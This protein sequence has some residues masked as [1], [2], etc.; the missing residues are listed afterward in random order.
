M[1]K[2]A[3]KPSAALR[4]VDMFT[5][6]TAVDAVQAVEEDA[7][8][9]LKVSETIETSAE[10][11]RANAMFTAEHLSKHWN[12]SKPETA[13]FRLTEK[14]GNLFL[15]KF[16]LDVRGEAYHWSGLMFRASDLYE[17]TSVFVKAAK[18]RQALKGA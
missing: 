7:K 4:T 17:L 18:E 10:R 9:S 6:M 14:D 13:K 16:S 5:G 15:E 1:S 12:E 8:D 11:W 2:V 3:K